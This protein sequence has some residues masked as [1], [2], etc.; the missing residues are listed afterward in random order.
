MPDRNVWAGR[1][2]AGVVAVGVALLGIGIGAGVAQAA[3][4]PPHT[5]AR[6]VVVMRNF[7]TGR[8]TDYKLANV[9]PFTG[10]Y[11]IYPV[12]DGEV[13]DVHWTNVIANQAYGNARYDWGKMGEYRSGPVNIA[14]AGSRA[15][16]YHYTMINLTLTQSWYGY[17]KGAYPPY[18]HGQHHTFAHTVIAANWPTTYLDKF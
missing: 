6:A 7:D 13:Y 4:V 18:G 3:T 11:G 8:I 2:I 10:E 16:P 17:T 9:D 15:D 12:G 1:K 14:V 5:P